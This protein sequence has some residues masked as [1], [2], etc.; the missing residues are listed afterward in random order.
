M[1]IT[2][3]IYIWMGSKREAGNKCG[4]AQ[5]SGDLWGRGKGLRKKETQKRDIFCGDSNL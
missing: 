1:S 4:T 3:G 5:N 2:L